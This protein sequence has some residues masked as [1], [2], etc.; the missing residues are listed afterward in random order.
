[1]AMVS[2]TSK[3]IRADQRLVE[4]G[5]AA[6]RSKAVALILAGEVL[7]GGKRVSKAGQTVP[8][9]AQLTLKAR[10]HPWVS[11][12]GVKLFHALQHFHLSLTGRTVLDLGASHGGFTDVALHQEAAK[13]FAVD[14]GKGQLDAKLRNDPR[15]IVMDKTNARHLSADT[16]PCLVDV[17]TCDASF[18]SLKTLLPGPLSLLKPH[19]VLIALIK[20]QFE[21]GRRALG[22][23]GVVRDPAV[24]K[25]VCE[26]ITAW[27]EGQGMNVHGVVASPLVGS[28][29][30]REFLIAAEAPSRAA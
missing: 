30:N 10:D 2:A 12:G 8:C 18:I 21:A 23:G 4:L 16:F 26:D 29:G 24:H 20:P 9:D 5:L 27:L 11:R 17:I 22:K 13:V 28:K 7:V 19:G 14:V 15:V 1:M 3:K 6:T 25:S